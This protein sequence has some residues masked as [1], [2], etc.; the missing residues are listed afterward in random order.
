MLFGYPIEAIKENWLHECLGTILQ[1]IHTYIQTGKPLPNWPEIVPEQYRKKL[2]RRTGLRDRLNAYYEV[3]VKLSSEQQCQ[4]LQTFKDQNEIPRLLS[5]QGECETINALPTLIHKPV[6]DLFEFAFSILT[7]L[8][9]RDR[10]YKIIYDKISCQTCPFCGCEDFDAPG[11]AREA[12]D[13]YLSKDKYPFAAAN[14]R[15]LVP[16]GNKCNSRYKLAQD[17]LIRN[18]GTRRKSFDPYNHQAV[19]ISLDNSQPFA[20]TTGKTGERLPRWEIDFSLNAEEVITWDDVF[21]IRERYQRDVLDQKFQSYLREF[22]NYCRSCKLVL[23][24]TEELLDALE[25]YTDFQESNEFKDRAFLKAA[26]FRMLDVHCRNGEQR[27]ID[28]I[29]DVV[30]GV[31][32]SE[33]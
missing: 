25:K 31:K 30:N 20:G 4:V 32:S 7:D 23:N 6:K 13:H 26:V 33:I 15:N 17:I 19:T 22:G 21:H 5:C 11:A 9:I 2:K 29:I 14:L 3:I 8:E 24:S 18:D 27:L 1:L 28:L 10:Q 12:L 16:I